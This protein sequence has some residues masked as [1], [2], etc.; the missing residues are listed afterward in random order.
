LL[1]I[2]VGAVFT[3]LVQSSAATTGI[4]IVM[5]SE[6]LM[7]LPAGIALALGSNI[8]TCATALLA[9]IGKPTDAVRAAM[10]H[11]IFNVAGV[12]LWV[13]FITYLA[14]LVT[15]ISPSYPNLDGAERSA[16]EVPRQ[17]ANAH[18]A[19]NVI[20]TLIFIGFTTQLARLVEWLVPEKAAKK[21]IIVEP[22]FLDRDI[23]DTPALAL[24]AVRQEIGHMGEI[25]LSMYNEVSPAIQEHDPE[26][27]NNIARRD[28]QV[29]ILND[30]IMTYLQLVHRGEL[31]EAQSVEFTRLLSATDNL[32]SLADVVETDLAALALEVIE[33]DIDP[34]ER[35]QELLQ[36][37][38]RLVAES[39]ELA[40]GAVRD[41][42]QNQ[43][44]QVM[45]MKGE[46]RHLSDKLL[47]R[48]AERLSTDTPGY[49]DQVRLEMAVV[50]QVRR[51]YTLAKRI[52]KTVLPEEVAAKD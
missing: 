52:A 20:N 44:Q 18:T 31:T 22:R 7:S 47:E 28:D 39:V 32:E 43:A 15:T 21:G 40:I 19:F 26:H 29:D 23:I 42:D 11:V 27:V 45:T 30:A 13:G 34:S 17:I 37:L 12:L 25:A 46:I 9:A 51:V 8:G 49:L 1:G 38:Y 33:K 2:L 3:A 14:D 4:A 24:Q 10:A 35:T 6:G 48:K 50:D 5:A 36:G 41:D 16:R